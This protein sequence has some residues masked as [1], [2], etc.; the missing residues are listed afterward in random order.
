M[1]TSMV[2]HYPK[3]I[4][5]YKTLRHSNQTWSLTLAQPSLYCYIVALIYVAME[6]LKYHT[7]VALKYLTTAALNYL[8]TAALKYFDMVVLKYH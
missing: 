5:Y 2:T 6:G 4:R 3:L 7:M 1:V 8:S